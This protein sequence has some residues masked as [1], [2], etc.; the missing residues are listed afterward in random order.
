MAFTVRVDDGKLAPDLGSNAHVRSSSPQKSPSLRR[1]RL[2]NPLLPPSVVT[3]SKR[4]RMM[5]NISI[6]GSPSLTI[7]CRYAQWLVSTKQTPLSEKASI[8]QQMDN[9]RRSMVLQIGRSTYMT[10]KHIPHQ[11][12]RNEVKSEV[13]SQISLGNLSRIYDKFTS[14]E[15][16]RRRRDISGSE[17]KTDAD[18]IDSIKNCSQHNSSSCKLIINSQTI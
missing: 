8:E 17:L 14:S 1:P 11:I 10:S 15:H 18:E 5:N 9:S 4:P 3:L 6:T 12:H 2:K 13:A 16:S 7:T